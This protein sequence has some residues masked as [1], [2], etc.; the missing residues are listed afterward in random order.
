MLFD[1]TAQNETEPP[2]PFIDAHTHSWLQG[3]GVLRVRNIFPDAGCSANLPDLFS[4]GIHPIHLED[5]ELTAQ[6]LRTIADVVSANPGRAVGVGECGL[7]H[8]SEHSIPRQIQVFTS[9]IEIA[10]QH[11]LPVVV[12]AVRTW[13]EIIRLKKL[14]D[15]ERLWLAHG[16]RSSE[17]TADELVDHGI[18]LSFGEALIQDERTREVF[19]EIPDDSFLLET[20]E[21]AIEIQKIYQV[22]ASI[23]DLEITE[24]RR[25]IAENFKRVFT[26]AD[27]KLLA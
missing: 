5:D 1:D 13:Y 4:I 26:T 18:L 23:R 7:D 3:G 11:G 15:P 9:Q 17:D 10:K 14:H 19:A 8:F 25:R 22:A 2:P 24:L 16:F 27:E 20:D 21:S 12:H 6:E